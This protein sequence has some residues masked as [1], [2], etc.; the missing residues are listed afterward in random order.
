M[1]FDGGVLVPLIVLLVEDDIDVRVAGGLATF[2]RCLC[3]E[4]FNPS[5][6]KV[7]MPISGDGAV[8]LTT[9][10]DGG[11]ELCLGNLVVVLANPTGIDFVIG[12]LGE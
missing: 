9:Q 12:V 8:V 11:G 4:I 7:I 2:H 10:H 3:A 5:D 6:G 1:I